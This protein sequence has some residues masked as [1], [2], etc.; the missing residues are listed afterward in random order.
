VLRRFA[1]MILTGFPVSE[2]IVLVGRETWGWCSNS[3]LKSLGG[4][5][6]DIGIGIGI[7]RLYGVR[8]YV[9]LG[10]STVV[11]SG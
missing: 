9:L 1:V 2:S 4:G 6:G 7:R 8:L 5:G 11:R 3:Y 10:E